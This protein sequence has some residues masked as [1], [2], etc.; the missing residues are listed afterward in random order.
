MSL[1]VMLFD[2]WA[3][4][5]DSQRLVVVPFVLHIHTAPNRHRIFHI[6][7]PHTR[8][9]PPKGTLEYFIGI[10]RRF[11]RFGP[12]EVWTWTKKPKSSFVLIIFVFQDPK[13]V[14]FLT[15]FNNSGV[16]LWSIPM[17]FVH[18][19]GLQCYTIKGYAKIV[20]TRSL[21]YFRLSV[22]RLSRVQCS[23]Y[24]FRVFE[25]FRMAV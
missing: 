14:S 23:G 12:R 9:P 3:V 7:S 21:V 11:L 6:A 25:P 22:P 5:S 2:F 19:T 13:G 24:S 10:P 18:K 17:R 16:I 4:E 15:F 20:N 8:T 1:V